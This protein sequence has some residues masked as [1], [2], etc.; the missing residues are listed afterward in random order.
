MKLGIIAFTQR[1]YELGERLGVLLDSVSLCRCTSGVLASW[2]REHFESDGALLF[3]GA[4]G[5]AVRAIAPY[6]NSKVHDPA[7]LVMD[8]M[9]RFV[10]PLISGHIGGAV[11]L[12]HKISGLLG[13]TPVIT[14]ATDVNGMFAID[15]WAVSCGFKLLHTENI[16]TVSSRILAGKDVR[17]KSDFPIEGKLPQSVTVDENYPHA[18]I[19]CYESEEDALHITPC[20]VT[21]GIGCRRG[22]DIADIEEAFYDILKSNGIC[23]QA[24]FRVCSIDLKVQEKGILEF[25]QKHS[26]EYITYSAETLMSIEGEFSKSE[27]VKSIT[28]VDCV[29]ERSAVL[30]S[31]GTLIAKKSVYNHVTMALAISPLVIKFGE[32]S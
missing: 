22:T 31:G 10:I 32:V 14:T 18:L 9:G 6:V 21:V 12:S 28:G 7:V 5:I 30:G 13:V 15:S 27:F 29:C 20:V 25:C 26:F 19:S 11:E 4:T 2:T 3:I 1:G 23:R 17:I 24:I 16:C 8:E